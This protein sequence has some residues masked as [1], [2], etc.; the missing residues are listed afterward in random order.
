T[1]SI[2][3]MENNTKNILITGATSGIGKCLVEFLVQNNG[4]HIYGIGRD[5]DKLGELVN[6]SN[7]TF[8]QFDLN[9]VDRIEELF[10]TQLNSI[11][12]SG[13]V[14][15]AGIEETLPLSLYVPSRIQSIFTL[16]V[17]SAIEILRILSKKKYSEDSASFI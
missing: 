5:A 4:N 15:C 10:S 8:I 2:K 16:N 7:F 13:F 14:H 11:K 3:R 1:V 17:F 12:F 9:N 6:K